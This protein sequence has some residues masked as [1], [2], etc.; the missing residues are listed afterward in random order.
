VVT[1]KHGAAPAR[2]QTLA[3]SK[4]HHIPA[5]CGC[6]RA[7]GGVH[8]PAAAGGRPARRAIAHPLLMATGEVWGA[9]GQVGRQPNRPQPIRALITPGPVAQTG[10][11]SEPICTFL[12]GAEQRSRL[13]P[14]E[15][16]AIWR[17]SAGAGPRLDP[18][19]ACPAPA[20][21]GPC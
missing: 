18:F 4:I 3:L 16:Y 2:G 12:L 6:S 21:L 7:A 20:N 11:R 5:T 13:W 9:L 17:R 14:L 1:S 15:I 10:S 8:R 19:R